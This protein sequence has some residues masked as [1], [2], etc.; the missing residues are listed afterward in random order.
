MTS[1]TDALKL[2]HP[3]A[4]GDTIAEVIQTMTSSG[5]AG[6]GYAVEVHVDRSSEASHDGYPM[7]ITDYTAG[8]LLDMCMSGPVAFYVNETSDIP[9][10]VIR[11]MLTLSVFVYSPEHEEDIEG[12]VETI[13]EQYMF[14]LTSSEIG[15]SLRAYSAD[16]YPSSAATP[17]KSGGEPINPNPIK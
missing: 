8:E 11:G 10:E 3:E 1:I 13:P 5:G 4:K 15:G 9:G 12:T 14:M 7:E 6:G 16:E 17:P 2:K